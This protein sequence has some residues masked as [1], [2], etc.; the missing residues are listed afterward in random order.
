MSALN[1]CLRAG[2]KIYINGAVLEAKNKISFS[3][4]NK[5]VF[6][7]ESHIIQPEDATTPFRQMYFIIQTIIMSPEKLNVIRGLFDDHCNG[8]K[9]TLENETLK[10]GLDEVISLVE[11]ERHFDAL[12]KV[13]ALFDVEETVLRA[14]QVRAA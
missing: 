8:L 7:I 2:E 12:K 6:L 13:R 3:L 1:I 10:S 5:A 4:L 14:P 11:N 9:A